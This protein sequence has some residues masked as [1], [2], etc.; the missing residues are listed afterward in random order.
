VIR[1]PVLFS[2]VS[3][4]NLA[5]GF[6]KSVIGRG[7]PLAGSDNQDRTRRN[8]GREMIEVQRRLMLIDFTGKRLATCSRERQEVV[9]QAKPFRLALNCRRLR[10]GVT[11][12]L[13]IG[14]DVPG[15]DQHGGSDPLCG[16]RCRHVSPH[17]VADD[18]DA[19]SVNV[20]FFRIL[21]IKHITNFGVRVLCGMESPFTPQEPR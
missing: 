20:V 4:T 8:G 16:S 5:Q 13:V 7:E 6:C 1:I 3:V 9:V 19:T 10:A 17:A 14:A 18:D 12:Q 2:D 11:P 15:G 21:G